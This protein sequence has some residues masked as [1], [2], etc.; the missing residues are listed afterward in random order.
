MMISSS[1]DCEGRTGQQLI[2]VVVSLVVFIMKFQGRFEINGSS[3]SS[4]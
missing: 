2:Q 4:A 1:V 3:A